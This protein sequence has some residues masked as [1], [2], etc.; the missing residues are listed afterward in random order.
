MARTSPPRPRSA[1]FRRFCSRHRCVQ[2]HAVRSGRARGGTEAGG[3]TSAP[4]RG[5]AVG[6]VSE[7]SRLAVVG[8]RVQAWLLVT[9]VRVGA[10]S[11]RPYYS[12]GGPMRTPRFAAAGAVLFVVLA[13]AGT[14]AAKPAVSQPA[15]GTLVTV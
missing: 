5:A 4:R 1:S 2:L 11:A 13:G 9:Q 7:N 6:A 14:A 12:K 15:T 3:V 8:Y 10:R